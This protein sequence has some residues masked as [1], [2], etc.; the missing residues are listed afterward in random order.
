MKVLLLGAAGQ[1]GQTLCAALPG[2]GQVVALDRRQADFAHQGRL[3]DLVR[4][5]APDVVVNAAAYTAVDKAEAEPE[6][7]HRVNAGAPAELAAAVAETGGWLIHYSTDYVFD[8]TKASPYI[9]EDETNPLGAYGRSKRDGERAIAAACPQ[10]LVFRTSW[11]HGPAGNTFAS[12]ILALARTRE[13]L[14]VV[15]D[16]IGAA[17]STDLIAEVTGRAISMIA[18]GRAASPGLYH[19]ASAGAG[20]WHDHACYIVEQAL[21][22]G[23]DLKVRPESIAPVPS[24]AY[25]TAAPRP[26]NSR[27]DTARLRAA[28]GIEPP[29]WR[30]ALQPTLAHLFRPAQA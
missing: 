29:D 9:E 28:F 25:A 15:S 8:G 12:K 23:L 21:A 30:Q 24:S 17:T 22:A 27:L 6:L 19:L 1:L 13:A 3:A 4:Q 11:V 16:Q 10:H 14:T 7:A 18:D 2:V 20:S 5:H 26:H